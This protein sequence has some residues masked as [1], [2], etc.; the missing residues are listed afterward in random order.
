[1]R[2]VLLLLCG[3]AGCQTAPPAAE[4]PL[5]Q[6]PPVI[7]LGGRELPAEAAAVRAEV[8]RHVAPG[9]PVQT[10]R[11]RLEELGFRC[12]Y[13]GV[14][15]KMPVSYHPTR[16]LPELITGRDAD[17]DRRFHS[18]V[19]KSERSEVGNWGR[20]Y[21]PV[22]VVLPYDEDRA[23][24][25]VEV[26]D[27]RPQ[28]SRYAGFF[29]R[30]PDLRE[31]VGLPVEEARAL[32]EAHKFRCS[33]AVAAQGAR[34]GLPYLDCQ[35]YIESLLGGEIVRVR[36]FYDYDDDR[37]VTEAEVV[38]TRGEFDDLQCMLPNSSDT[39]AEGALKALVFPARL[40]AALVVGGLAASLALGRP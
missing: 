10:A 30:R 11:A 28:V 25:E 12:R 3:V 4:A 8:L 13:G 40:Y 9:L 16:T 34:P 29:A 33:P 35:A 1:M 20:R 18:L 27:F 23:V 22:T 32:L 36:L 6:A 7:R 26:P 17:R 39:P 19:C 15:D 14:L 21:F 24:T 2:R 37:T 5:A 31:P 38:Q